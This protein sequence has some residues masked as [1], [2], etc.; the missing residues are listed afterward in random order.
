MLCVCVCRWKGGGGGGRGRGRQLVMPGRCVS[1][2]QQARACVR[3]EE[4]W[5]WWLWWPNCPPA[6]PTPPGHHPRFTHHH[7]E[8]QT[9]THPPGEV[10]VPEHRVEGGGEAGGDDE[11][12]QREGQQLGQHVAN[13]VLRARAPGFGVWGLFRTLYIHV[14]WQTW[15]HLLPGLR[16]RRQKDALCCGWGMG[17][18]Q[19]G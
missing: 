9:H 3:V 6:P 12:G 17:G 19:Q 15:Q 13:G 14:H 7:H 5:C 10:A 4:W 11:E 2:V 8:P 16:P 1:T 18:G